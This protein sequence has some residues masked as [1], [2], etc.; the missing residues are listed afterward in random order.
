MLH[1]TDRSRREANHGSPRLLQAASGRVASA[2]VAL[3]GLVSTSSS[4]LAQTCPT[5]PPLG[6]IRVPI[7]SRCGDLASGTA[8]YSIDNM[9][10][11]VNN[12]G[13]YVTVG[14]RLIPAT[15]LPGLHVIRWSPTW[16]IVSEALYSI[17]G[18]PN[19][20]IA[21][22]SVD[23]DANCNLLV[24]GRIRNTTT[25][26][27]STFV[28][29]LTSTLGFVNAVRLAGP[30]ETS[31][32]VQADWLADGTVAMYDRLDLGAGTIASRVGRL[33]PNLGTMW[34]R[35]YVS[36]QVSAASQFR[37]RD[38]EQ[39]PSGNIFVSGTM[40]WPVSVGTR[41][42]P[43]V[44][45]FNLATGAMVNMRA[46]D[47]TTISPWTGGGFEAIKFNPSAGALQNQIIVAGWLSRPGATQFDPPVFVPQ[48]A[49][50]NPATLAQSWH[51]AYPA[52]GGHIPATSAIGIAPSTIPATNHLT[53]AGRV[54]S[55]FG[56]G[57]GFRA[58]TLNVREADGAVNWAQRLG[59]AVS[60]F[61]SYIGADI[62]P[63]ATRKVIGYFADN[64]P[65]PGGGAMLWR[66]EA[67]CPTNVTAS[68]V[69]ISP[70]PMGTGEIVVSPEQD[71]L[72]ITLQAHSVMSAC[73]T[74]CRGCYVN[75]DG[76][77]VLPF[78][79]IND[80]Q[81]FLNAFAAGDEYANCDESTVPPV[82]N[83]N[84]FQCFLNGY[85]AGCT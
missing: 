76:S 7:D 61:T 78:L 13:G 39:G 27:N 17:S 10:G 52:L 72:P 67:A 82:L 54:D 19:E 70:I 80:F 75:C 23:A 45:E 3:A 53:I 62:S 24:A 1:S 20:S 26:A 34:V 63:G 64:S 29:R 31:V 33:A 65:F 42:L 5:P 84:D 37:I 44:M 47:V 14:Q 50:I 4:A 73:T 32:D 79:N 40:N 12:P 6:Q 71:T 38:I 59:G 83:V 28:A 2:T 8:H 77:T 36:Q 85:A 11:P 48:A 18:S 60:T 49:I 51:T 43:M 16:A 74:L 22:T 57:G 58:F 15:G 21:G 68:A 25:G 56:S 55:G 30:V 69:A 46:Y 66:S 41:T 35:R 81:C 9:G